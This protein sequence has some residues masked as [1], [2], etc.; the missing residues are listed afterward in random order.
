MVTSARVSSTAHTTA[1][2]SNAEQAREQ[3]DGFISMRGDAMT[4][5][6][7]MAAAKNCQVIVARGQP[8][9]LPA[10]EQLVLM[11][12]NTIAAARAHGATVVLPEAPSTTTGRTPSRCCTKTPPTPP[13]TQGALRV[14]W[15]PPQQATVPHPPE[16]LPRDHRARGRLPGTDAGPGNSWFAQGLVRPG[17]PVTTVKQPGAPGIG[18]QWSYLPDVARAMALLLERR[19]EAPRVG[20]LS[21]GRALGC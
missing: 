7:V 5:A 13:H 10:L 20:P 18:H 12:D 17:R 2:P 6:D 9:R 14:G 19:A 3:R 8:A 4:R 21:S 16:S 15:A 11:I 1:G